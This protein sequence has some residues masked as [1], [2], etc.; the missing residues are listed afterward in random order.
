[1]DGRNE[2]LLKN[3]T[4][5]NAAIARAII[6]ALGMHAENMQREILGY[7]MAYDENA[8]LSLID[9]ECIEHND[10]LSLLSV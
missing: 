10:I 8:F 7:S 6:K 5:A 2:I 4:I 9:E 1:M 3:L